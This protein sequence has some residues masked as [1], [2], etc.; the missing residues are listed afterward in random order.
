M[1]SRRELYLDGPRRSSFQSTGGENLRCKI[2][3]C[4]F[5]HRLSHSG[6][7]GNYVKVS[8]GVGIGS[9]NALEG[10]KNV[11]EEYVARTEVVRGI[12]ES[13]YMTYILNDRM[14]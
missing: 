8:R 13:D 7:R 2:G 1:V 10:P 9:M 3:S 6:A 14:G 4:V 12:S 5:R 11:S